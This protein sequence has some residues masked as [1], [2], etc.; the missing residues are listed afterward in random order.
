MLTTGDNVIAVQATNLQGN[1]G[2]CAKLVIQYPDREQ[3]VIVSDKQ[4]KASEA[5]AEGWTTL[6]FNDTDWKSAAEVTTY[7]KGVWGNL[8]NNVPVPVS[9]FRKSI[10]LA[11]KKIVSVLDSMLPLWDL[12]EMRLNGR[13][14]GDHILA[15]EWTDY[16]KR[17]RYQVYDVTTCSSRATTQLPLFWPTAGIA[18][19]SALAIF[20]NGEKFP[21]C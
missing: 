15:P 11:D 10:K 20:R 18:G 6:D 13:R 14:I 3:N 1:A 12:Y 7:G 16:N 2:V 9:A 4:W 21:R 19:I 17:V 5:T 8:G